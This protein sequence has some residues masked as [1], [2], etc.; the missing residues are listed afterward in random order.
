[1]LFADV[2]MRKMMGGSQSSLISAS[3][4]KFYVLKL[5]GNPQGPY[6][7]FNETF[8]TI[9]AKS[10]GLPVPDWSPIY[11]DSSFIRTNTNLSFESERGFYAAHPG[12]HFGSKFVTA[13]GDE[14]IYEIVPHRWMERVENPQFFTG[15][16]FLDIWTEN[17]D[18]RQALF[19][20]RSTNR[21]LR[22]VFFDNGHMFKGPYAKKALKNGRACLF[23]HRNVYKRAFEAESAEA[24]LLRIEGLNE[25]ILWA[26]MEEVPR[27]WRSREIERDTMALLMRNQRTLRQKTKEVIAEFYHSEKHHRF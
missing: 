15:M 10:L 14:E 26:M 27:E 21:A 23:S 17:V 5:A 6:T 9:L 2:F 13:S 19:I 18:S 22:V 24:W 12:L 3:D 16:L 4:G 7:L 8:G 20:Q 11:V 1:M 25:R